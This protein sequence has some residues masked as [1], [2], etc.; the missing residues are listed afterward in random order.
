[1]LLGESSW[2]FIVCII[3][4]RTF[5]PGTEISQHNETHHLGGEKDDG[6]TNKNLWQGLSHFLKAILPL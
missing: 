1:M 2:L 4:H 5:S 6:A 3:P